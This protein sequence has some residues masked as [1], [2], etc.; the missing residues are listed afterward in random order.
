[1]YSGVNNRLAGG[2]D[3]I[4]ATIPVLQGDWMFVIKSNFNEAWGKTFSFEVFQAD[5]FTVDTICYSFPRDVYSF[6]GIPEEHMELVAK[7]AHRRHQLMCGDMTSIIFCSNHDDVVSRPDAFV[8]IVKRPDA[9]DL[10]F[11][12]SKH[13]FTT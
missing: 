11:L 2:G 7:T 1:M 4:I 5:Q 6:P 10:V 8:C 13:W 12:V 3:N 9:P